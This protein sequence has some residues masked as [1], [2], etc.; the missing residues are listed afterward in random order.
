M[1]QRK[2]IKYSK[3]VPGVTKIYSPQISHF[4]LRIDL[5]EKSYRL[6]SPAETF[7]VICITLRFVSSRQNNMIRVYIINDNSD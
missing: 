2:A 5:R 3:S 7:L 6:L 4:L 1:K